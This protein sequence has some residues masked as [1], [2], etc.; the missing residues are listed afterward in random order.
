MSKINKWVRL[1]IQKMSPYSSAREEYKGENAV[2]LDANE[3]PF[4]EYNR[5][6]DPFQKK[7]KNRISEL[8][9]IPS[10]NLF[11][12][13][14]SDEA[15]DLLFRIFCQPAKDKAVQWQPTY[16]MYQV[17]ADINEVEMISLAL[18]ADFDLEQQ[19]LMPYLNKENIKLMFLCSPNNPSGNCLDREKVKWI[20]ESF[21]GIVVIDEAYAEFS[22]Q[23]SWSNHI[24]DYSN[25]VVLQTLSKAWGMAGLRIG[26]AMAQPEII[27]YFNKVKPPYNISRANQELA[28]QKLADKEGFKRR[29]E[30][31]LAERERLIRE[32]RELPV[33]ERVYPTE[34]NFILVKVQ[35][36]DHLYDQLLEKG[37][38][39][40]NR[41]KLVKDA[42]RITVGTKAENNLLI[43]TL[44]NI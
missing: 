24:N 38:V 6:P 35:H 13:N 9:S 12:G 25:L 8:K 3:N 30:N 29:I 2:F 28:I 15:I 41:S 34:A 4:G 44:Q 42:L 17:A 21:E 22:S 33:I 36:A 7:L 27:N 32:L 10:A 39:V 23:P 26:I 14:G 1:N 37:V 11:L 16:G 20:L 19:S 40:R 31:I 43:N 18:N 5:Y